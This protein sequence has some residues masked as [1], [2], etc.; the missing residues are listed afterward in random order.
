M[1]GDHSV[2]ID[3]TMLFSYNPPK[4]QW[5]PVSLNQLIDMSKS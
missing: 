4:R 1:V 3:G 2:Y 5:L